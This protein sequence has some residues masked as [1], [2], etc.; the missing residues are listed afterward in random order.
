MK[1]LFDK[2][3][4]YDVVNN[5]LPGVITV[6][7]INQILG[8]YTTPENIIV[9][10]F[11]YYFIG[12]IISRIGSLVIDPVL[13]SL[14]IITKF[15]NER[16]INAT[17]KD[18]HLKVLSEVNNMYRTFCSMIFTILVILLL[19]KLI[20]LASISLLKCVPFILMG[21]LLLY[22]LSYRKQ[23]SFI[24]SRIEEAEK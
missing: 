19:E 18:D 11:Y 13:G 12:N 14:K 9:G 24:K 7:L 2:I 20:R 8:Y 3:S 6:N 10:F 4:S 21:V 15:S 22:I 1:E 16:Y 17:K 5:V 23:T